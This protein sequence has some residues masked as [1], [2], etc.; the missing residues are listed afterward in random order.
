MQEIMSQNKKLFGVELMPELPEVET[1]LRGIKPHIL[2]KKVTNVI[3]R[4]KQLRWPIPDDIKNNLYN[5]EPI[6]LIRRGKYIIIKFTSGDLIIHLGMSG[7]LRILH[8][9]QE[10]EKHDHVDIEFLNKSVILRYTDPRRFGSILWCQ[11]GLQHPLLAKLGVEP[12]ASEFNADYLYKIAKT[13][14]MP[15]KSFIMDS[16]IVVGVGNIY[17]TEALFATQIHPQTPAKLITL[18]KMQYLVDTIKN[19]LQDAI[20]QGGTTLKDFLSSDGKPGYFVQK[21]QA[22]GRSGKPCF[23]CKTTL[24]SLKIGQRTTSFCPNCQST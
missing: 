2:A 3:V 16:K 18:E 19:V 15:I 5:N 4:Q 22:Y 6:S 8:A 1:T 11:D 14:T 9:Y 10:P 13:K 12:L 23:K 21:L 17:A 24:R 7:R 20:V